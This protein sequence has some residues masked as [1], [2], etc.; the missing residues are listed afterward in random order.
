MKRQEVHRQKRRGRQVLIDHN[1]KLGFKFRHACPLHRRKCIRG[2]RMVARTRREHHHELIENRRNDEVRE[3]VVD[4]ADAYESEDSVDIPPCTW[5]VD[6]HWINWTTSGQLWHTKPYLTGLL[7][8][9]DLP[10]TLRW[11]RV[12]C[13]TVV[14]LFH[15]TMNEQ[16]LLI[17]YLK[18]EGERA[19]E[20]RWKGNLR[21]PR[22]WLY[23]QV[24]DRTG[25]ELRFSDLWFT[26]SCVYAILKGCWELGLNLLKLICSSY[27]Y[28]GLL[29]T[30]GWRF[31]MV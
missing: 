16:R 31:G 27:N 25:K 28:F 15:L 14:I 20:K 4:A 29:H 24:V 26:V 22:D 23:S 7:T 5:I 18:V 11:W 19:N 10:P 8:R 3:L 6:Q 17:F 21:G 1:A 13:F 30:L 2:R 12:F 9:D